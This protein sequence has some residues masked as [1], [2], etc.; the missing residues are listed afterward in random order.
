M[1]G[2]GKL[3]HVDGDIYEG[4]WAFDMAHGFGAYAHSGV[5]IILSLHFFFIL[6][7]RWWEIRGIVVE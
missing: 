1:H 3:I 6:I 4:E 7:C 5:L 2:K